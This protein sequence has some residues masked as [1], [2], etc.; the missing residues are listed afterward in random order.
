MKTCNLNRRQLL[1]TAAIAASGLS[2]PTMAAGASPRPQGKPRIGCLSWCFHNL[3]PGADPEPAIDVIGGLGFEGVELIVNAPNDLK[4]FWT[5]AR[6]DRFN[7]KLQKNKLRVSQ[8]VLF[9]PVVEDL[10]STNGTAR[11]QALN[12]FEAG[13]R[14]GKKLGAPMINIVAPWARELKGPT[15]YLPRYYE[16]VNPKPGQKY[17]IDIAENFDW[18]RVWD[19]YV[20]TTK[21]C[22]SRAKAHGMKFSIEQ[23][24]HCLVPDAASFLRLWDQIQDNDLGYNI[25]VGWTLLQREYPPVAIHKVGRHLMNV[26]MRDIDGLMRQFPAFGR[27]VM[28]VE[29][30]VTALK[31]VG[32]NGFASIEQDRHPGDPDIKDTCREYLRIMR[33]Y[34]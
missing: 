23:H 14:I 32:F 19:A 34:I 21:A 15:S 12:N 24:T 6:I 28:D 20:Q 10:S 8:F 26:H 27:G 1:Q 31:K 13:C 5:D 29:A 9:Q 16:I 3:S 22:L 7:Q 2:L 30:I 18:D 25:D 4:E 11:E 33:Q 17:H